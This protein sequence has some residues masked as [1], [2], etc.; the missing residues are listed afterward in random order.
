MDGMWLARLL[1]PRASPGEN[2]G[3]GRHAL[4]QGVSPTQG[5]PGLL[6]RQAGSL[7]SAPPGKSPPASD[8]LRTSSVVLPSAGVGGSLRLALPGDL[9]ALSALGGAQ[10]MV[11]PQDRRPDSAELM[12]EPI[13]VF[14]STTVSQEQTGRDGVSGFF[15]PPREGGVTLT[16]LL[17]TPSPGGRLFQER[18]AAHVLHHGWRAWALLFRLYYV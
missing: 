2:A 9:G 18:H 17:H 6:H 5:T 7:R 1:C 11:G 8:S 10:H 4:L 3:A 15:R 14:C 16:P 12:G 13:S